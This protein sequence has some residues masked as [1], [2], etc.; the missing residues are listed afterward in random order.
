MDDLR[1]F[2]NMWITFKNSLIP[3]R[4]ITNMLMY[5]NI[6]LL[7]PNLTLE[8]KRPSSLI[9]FDYYEIRIESETEYS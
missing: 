6:H 9:N 1:S 3:Y 7:F 8:F 5:C 2:V 4:Y